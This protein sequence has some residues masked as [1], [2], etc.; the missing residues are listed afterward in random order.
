[1]TLAWAGRRRPALLEALLVS[2]AVV[3][4]DNSAIRRS[5]LALVLAARYPR[6]WPNRHRDLP[7]PPCSNH[8]IAGWVGAWVRSAVPKRAEVAARDLVLFRGGCLGTRARQ[9]TRRRRLRPRA[10][11]VRVTTIAFFLAE[12]GDKNR[13]TVMLAAHFRIAGSG[14]GR[15]D[16]GHDGRERSH[17]LPRPC[18]CRAHSHFAQCALPFRGAQHMGAVGLRKGARPN[19]VRPSSLRRYNQ[20]LMTP[21]NHR[22]IEARHAGH[23]EHRDV[24]R[25]R[26]RPTGPSTTRAR[27]CLPLGRA[28]HGP[29]A[30]LHHRRRCTGVRAGDEPAHP[31][32]LGRVRLAGRER[33]DQER[34][35]RPASGRSR[36]SRR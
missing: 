15:H 12:I 5:S 14:R 24:Y 13:D 25:M 31:D 9:T 20:R 35:R 21:F 26:E 32:G 28:A 30:Q 4:L 1:M 17:R 3:R 34:D 22:D 11:R 29:R 6:P 23:V 33:G 7:S 18:G 10:G 8:T 2:I 27:C 36:T 19:G 16:V